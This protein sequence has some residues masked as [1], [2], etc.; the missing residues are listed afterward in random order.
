MHAIVMVHKMQ[1]MA[2]SSHTLLPESESTRNSEPPVAGGSQATEQG[3]P[4]SV[5]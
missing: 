1:R 4:G 5:W 3:D 2:L